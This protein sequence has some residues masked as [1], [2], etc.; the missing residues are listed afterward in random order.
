MAI[1]ISSP[2]T[3]NFNADLYSLKSLSVEENLKN[4]NFEIK[5]LDKHLYFI[6]TDT[7]SSINLGLPIIDKNPFENYLD[8]EIE[9]ENLLKRSN[10]MHL[11]DAIHKAKESMI[12]YENKWEKYRKQKALLLEDL[13][14]EEEDR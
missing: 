6:K 5:P 4:E 1:F 13:F 12:L 8:F 14:E 2:N 11:R 9:D 10:K 3:I 7:I